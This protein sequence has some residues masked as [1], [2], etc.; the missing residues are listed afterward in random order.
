MSL[1]DKI[2]ASSDI[3]SELVDIPEWGVT[4]EVRGLTASARAALMQSA[5]DDGGR[6]NLASVYP[7]M[8]IGCTYDPDTGDKVFTD[9]DFA[10]LGEKS[11]LAVERIA[12]AAMSL[13]GMTSASADELG[14]VSSD[15]PSE[16]S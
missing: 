14:N 11:G 5:A 12:S 15:I 10:A 16:D 7:T 2:L 1:R 13:S 8:V 6:V 4:V 3:Q 9:G